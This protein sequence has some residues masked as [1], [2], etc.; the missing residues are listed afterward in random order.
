[1]SDLES[2]QANLS[3]ALEVI[4]PGLLT[5]LQDLGRPTGRNYGIPP[6]GAL[7]RFAHVAANQL[8]QNPPGAATLEITLQGPRLHFQTSALIAITGA[9]LR[10]MLD[11]QPIPLWMSVFGR[12]GQT[13]EFGPALISDDTSKRKS[14]GGRAY[15]AIHGGFDAPLFLGS[16]S[17]YLRAKLGGYAGQG[18]A[19]KA[20]DIL[21]SGP[22]EIR[23]FP[24]AAGRLLPPEQRPAY[25]RAVAV[26]VVPGPFQEN[27]NPAAWQSLLNAT[28]TLSHQSDRMGFRLDGPP[29]AHVSPTLAEIAACG[30]VY[31]AIQVP[32][33]GQPIILMADHQVTGGY[34]II[35]TVLSADLPLLAQLLPGDEVRFLALTSG[36]A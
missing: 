31:G 34:P 13:L 14:W 19:L 9:D 4:A 18:R 23:Q 12:A 26:R 30:A 22:I 17:T 6:G 36:I 10:P 29:L 11:N 27:F 24:E 20:K 32:A 15:L 33:N 16:R 7:D 28:Y 5:T 21:K 35:G 8:V 25:G 3:S 1:M 2:G